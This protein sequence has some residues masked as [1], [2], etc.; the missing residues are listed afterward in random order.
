MREVGRRDPRQARFLTL[1]SLRW[2]I[3]N[4]AWTPWYLIRYLRL[5]RL[6]L[7]R[8]DIVLEGMVFLGK[9]VRFEVRR[10]YG[11]IVVGRWVHIGSGT[12]FRAHEGTMRIGD[13]CV[14]GSENT[15]NCYVDVEFGAGT[16]IAD[17]VYVTDFDHVYADPSVPI[18]DQGL[19]KSPVRIGPGSWLGVKVTVLRGA[20]TGPN[21]V[22]SPPTPWSRAPYRRRAW[23]P[24]C[25]AGWSR[26]SRRPGTS[27]PNNAPMSPTWPANRPKPS[28][29]CAPPIGNPP[30][31][32]R[33]S[34]KV[35]HSVGN[36]SVPSAR[37]FP[38]GTTMRR[39]VGAR[40]C[41][42]GGAAASSRSSM[43]ACSY[44]SMTCSAIRGQA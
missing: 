14:F 33:P 21:C 12:K 42:T 16:L 20:S 5:A 23:S 44:V 24:A 30:D 34:D 43:T 39:G 40:P 10:G 15:I 38:S 4:R 11:R 13:K 19:A 29:S 1:A 7:T 9:K 35:P 41:A 36:Q 26:T 2:V 32:R 31:Q 25:R 37:R 8:R 6:T 18:K 3:R 27:L 17:W 28:A 22:F